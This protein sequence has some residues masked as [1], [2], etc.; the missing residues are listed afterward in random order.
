MKK[1]F[2]SLM[3]AAACAASASAQKVVEVLDPG[4]ISLEISDSEKN[5]ITDLTVKGQ[6][7]G[8]DILFLVEMA[9]TTVYHDSEKTPGKLLHLDLSEAQIVAGG[10]L[11]SKYPNCSTADNTVGTNMFK[12][13]QLETLIL[14]S[15]TA[16][17]GDNAF[18]D[19][20]S[21]TALEVPAG[22]TTIGSYAFHNCNQMASI[23]LPEG[24]TAIKDGTFMNCTRLAEIQVPSTVKT[25]GSNVFNNTALTSITLPEG[26]TSVGYDVFCHS[27]REIH[28]ES[29][30]APAT[31]YDSFRSVNTSSCTLY[32][33]KGTTAIY[34]ANTEWNKFTTIIEEEP[35]PDPSAHLEIKLAAPG[36]LSIYITPEQILN[37]QSL[38]ISGP[39]NAS[40]LRILRQM[41]GSDYEFKPTSGRLTELEMEDATIVAE[42]NLPYAIH[43]YSDPE[44]PVLLCIFSAYMDAN[45]MLPPMAFEGCHIERIVLPKALVTLASA[46][47]GCPLK[48]TIVIPEGV[49]HIRDYAFQGCSQLEGIVLPSTLRNVPT[50]DYLYPYAIGAHAFEGCSSLASIELPEGVTILPDYVLA[51]TGLTSLTLPSSI[52]R[53]GSSALAIPGLTTLTVESATPPTAGYE[54]F[55]GIQFDACQLLIPEGAEPAYRNAEEWCR[56]FGLEVP[57]GINTLSHQLSPDSP[58]FDLSGRPYARQ[59]HGIFIQ[60]GKKVIR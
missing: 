15:S 38:K 48:G 11:Y 54:A 49:T 21:L 5:T 30:E 45:N 14:P 24:L 1:I 34:R 4:T 37:C 36:T 2:I 57:E 46:F 55:K 25:L 56:F 33:P 40:D 35:K 6:L 8:T 12:N 47:T 53:L 13:T 42:E 58:A 20:V 41:A 31:V 50:E 10:A 29:R 27:I 28:L 23:S 39:I 52:N 22:V 9:G 59:A 51:G 7:D 26:L 3:C 18:Y 32:I 16:A 60:N 19:C 17:I 43:P 44:N